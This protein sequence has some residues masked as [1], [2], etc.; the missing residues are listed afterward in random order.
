MEERQYA[1]SKRLEALTGLLSVVAVRLLQLRG[2]ARAEPE[3]PAMQ[4]V[5]AIWLKALTS[6]R[7]KLPEACTIRAFYR[8]LAGLGGFLGR[9]HDGEPGWITLW[10]G[11]KQ[12]ALAVR[13]L[14]CNKKC[15]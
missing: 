5:P 13:V 7:R 3:R 12:L 8:N 1:T 6:L 4:V 9:K 10:R 14:E 11:F 2:V 15:G